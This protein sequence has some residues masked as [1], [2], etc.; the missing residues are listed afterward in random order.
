MRWVEH[1]EHGLVPEYDLIYQS[2]GSIEG[3]SFVLADGSGDADEEDLV[4]IE[5][6]FAHGAESER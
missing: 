2:G 4:P 6:N 5:F 1:E 3:E